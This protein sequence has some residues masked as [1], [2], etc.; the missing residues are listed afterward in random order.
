MP[1]FQPVRRRE[2]GGARSLERTVL[3]MAVF[4]ELREFAGNFHKFGPY[5][6][7]F[8][9]IHAAISVAYLMNSLNIGAGKK[10]EITGKQNR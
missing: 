2:A 4:P 3:G 9:R 8:V 7:A 6:Q 10:F 1:D 5:R